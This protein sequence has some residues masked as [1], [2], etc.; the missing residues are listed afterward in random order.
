MELIDAITGRRSVRRY[1]EKVVSRELLEELMATACW[2]PSADNLQPWYFVVLTRE[3][4]IRLMQETME[5]V[6]EEI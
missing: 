6:A 5:K 3:A 4:D 1:Q 2:A